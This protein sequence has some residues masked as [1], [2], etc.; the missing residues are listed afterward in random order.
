M[1]GCAITTHKGDQQGS[2]PVRLYV[3]SPRERQLALAGEAAR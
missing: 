3:M 2:S 1:A